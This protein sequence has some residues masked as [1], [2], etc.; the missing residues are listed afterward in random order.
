MRSLLDLL[1][2]LELSGEDAVHPDAAA[3]VLEAVGTRLDHLS[4]VE[5]T[6][7]LA[8][9]RKM[10]DETPDPERAHFFRGFGHAQGWEDG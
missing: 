7:L 2:F 4:A 9:S 10:A 8:C 3:N 5:R 1:A 6:E